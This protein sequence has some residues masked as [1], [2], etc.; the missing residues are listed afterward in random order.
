MYSIFP[1]V[2]SKIT[3][4]SFHFLNCKNCNREYQI[5]YDEGLIIA[6]KMQSNSKKMQKIEY[7]SINVTTILRTMKQSD[8]TIKYHINVHIRSQVRRQLDHEH[9]RFSHFS[10]PWNSQRP[11][12]YNLNGY[13]ELL[14][15]LIKSSNIIKNS[16]PQLNELSTKI[17]KSCYK[18]KTNAKRII[19]VSF[20]TL[21]M[22]SEIQLSEPPRSK[23]EGMGEEKKNNKF[24][25]KSIENKNYPTLPDKAHKQ[26]LNLT[27]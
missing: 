1:V 25:P 23:N 8:N 13:C 11:T 6:I 12:S 4:R 22:T 10:C 2:G 15:D 17:W 18:W 5:C 20:L 16:L 14:S 27:T 3:H 19:N 24:S 21:I 9:G 7:W 26:S